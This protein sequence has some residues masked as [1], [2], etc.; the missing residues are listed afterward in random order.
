MTHSVIEIT[1]NECKTKF[2]GVLNDLFNVSKEYAAACPFCKK[3]S[4]FKGSAAIIDAEIPVNAVQIMYVT[5]PIN[6]Y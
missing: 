6:E 5:E 2:N 4:F 1:C 3:Q